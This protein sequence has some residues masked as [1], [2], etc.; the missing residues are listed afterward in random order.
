MA[1]LVLARTIDGHQ[2]DQRRADGYVNATALCKAAGKVWNDYWRLDATQEFVKA[3]EDNTG[4]NRNI[5]VQATRGRTGGTWVH[6]DLAVN[7]AQ[8]CSPRFAVQ[9]SRWVRELLTDGRVELAPP[10]R[11][12]LLPYTTRVMEMIPVESAVPDGPGAS[13]WKRPRC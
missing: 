2:I 6:P 8:W 7:L 3:L 10:P 1:G 11:P 5:L 13:S 12:T 4:Q 9:V